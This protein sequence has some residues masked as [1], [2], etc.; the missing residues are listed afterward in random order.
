[1][2]DEPISSINECIDLIKDDMVL[3]IR[4][5]DNVTKI[6]LAARRFRLNSVALSKHM[7]K[8]RKALLEENK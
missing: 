1:M 2:I 4:D 7:L 6:K 8:L 3:I 5:L